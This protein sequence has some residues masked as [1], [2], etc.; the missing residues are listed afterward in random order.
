MF[1]CDDAE[2]CALY[3]PLDTNGRFKFRVY[4]DGFAPKT[5]KFGEFSASN[6]IRIARLLSASKHHS[7]L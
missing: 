7:I 2:N 4:A 1:T 3:I 6:T 5:Q